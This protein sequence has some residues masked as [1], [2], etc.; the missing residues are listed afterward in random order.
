MKR[1]FISCAL[2]LCTISLSAQ[3][4]MSAKEAAVKIA[5]RILDSTTYEFKNTKT[6][7]VYKSVKRLP[8][9]MDVKVACKYNNW[10]YTNGVTNIALMELADKVGDQKEKNSFV[11]FHS[12]DWKTFGNRKGYFESRTYDTIL[13]K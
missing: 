4:K 5:D 9:S 12:G 1:I 8:L 3:T 11:L 13:C 10:H 6:G 2:F 7:E